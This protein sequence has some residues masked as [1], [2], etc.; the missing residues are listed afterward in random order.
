[1]F[2]LQEYISES[3]DLLEVVQD[4]HSGGFSVFNFGGRVELFDPLTRMSYSVKFLSV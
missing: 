1:M 3:S 2:A 4:G